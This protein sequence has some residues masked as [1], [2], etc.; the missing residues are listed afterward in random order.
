MD[1]L[2]NGKVELIKNGEVVSHDIYK[3]LSDISVGSHIYL[4]YNI[5]FIIYLISLR[6]KSFITLKRIDSELSLKYDN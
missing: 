2:E 3:T 4:F 5:L 6:K 1:F